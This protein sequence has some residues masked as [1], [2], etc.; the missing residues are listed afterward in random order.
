MSFFDLE[1]QQGPLTRVFE[2]NLK[3]IFSVAPLFEAENIKIFAS[4]P[5]K[6]YEEV[7]SYFLKH[8]IQLYPE[9]A[10]AEYIAHRVVHGGEV[11]TACTLL[12]TVSE[13]SF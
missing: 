9:L 4:S 13:L 3:E 6:S 12:E 1:I 10:K 8:A 11:F 5:F 2:A 7:L